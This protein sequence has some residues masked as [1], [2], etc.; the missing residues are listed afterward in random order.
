MRFA[1]ALILLAAGCTA[2]NPAYFDG[3]DD[4]GGTGSASGSGEATTT[5]AGTS[6]ASG[7]AS[8]VAPTTAHDETSGGEAKVDVAGPEETCVT[9][10]LPIEED[11]FLVSTLAG[12][13]RN[14][15]ATPL[16][17]LHDVVNT[18]SHA[19]L[20][21][22]LPDLG[23]LEAPPDEAVLRVVASVGQVAP[24]ADATI[25]LSRLEGATML[26]AMFCDWV[27]GEGDDTEQVGAVTWAECARNE[28][29]WP[30]ETPLVGLVDA[31]LAEMG[32]LD[33]LADGPSRFSLRLDPQLDSG[34]SL[35]LHTEGVGIEQLLV[36]ASEQPG[37]AP[38][39]ELM[40]C[41]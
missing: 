8:G 39:L 29:G 7:D 12:E 20:L 34:A 2:L 31:P 21:F 33:A 23:M 41:D 27:E 17:S 5:P 36:S 25:R 37:E 1:G 35:V 30:W 26:T 40:F 9:M 13:A 38:I 11:A 16:R 18:D 4:V 19:V 6:G 28:G 3:D 22:R 24:D 15:G 14:Y 32:V 10:E